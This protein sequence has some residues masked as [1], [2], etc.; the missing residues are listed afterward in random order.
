[1]E[2][3]DR[4]HQVVIIGGGFAGLFAARALRRAPVSV[5]LVD[6]AANHLFQPLLYQ[7]ATGILS[8]GKIAF[9]L[10]SLLSRH[11][12]VEAVLAEV[13]DFDA[14]ERK[15]LAV[16]P[17][18]EPVEFDYDELILAAGV[19]QSY[20]GHEEFAEFAPGMK[21]IDD[22]LAIRDRVFGAFEMAESAT[23]EQERRDWLTFALVGAGPTGVEL[24]GQ[25]RELATK[26]L[27]QEYRHIQPE[28]ARVLLLDAGDAPLASFG[29]K[30]SGKAA[31][32]LQDL[33]V[34]LHMKSMVTH[35]DNGWL[36]ARDHD[37]AERRY[38]AA[39]I[40]WTAGV[41]APPVAQALAQAAGA[42]RDKAGRIVVGPDLT[43]PDHPEISVIGDVMSL[44]D[45]PGVAEVAMQSGLYA[46]RRIRQRLAGEQAAVKPFRYYD[47]GSAAYIARGNAVVS[48]GPVQLSGVAGWISWL[49]IHLAFLT[50]VRNRLGAII[51]WWPAF[52]RD[53]RRERAYTTQQIE[54]LRRVY[55]SGR[56]AGAAEPSR[57]HEAAHPARER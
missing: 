34:E 29:A 48:A 57:P 47:L 39:T 2:S 20:F 19:E 26:T 21:T 41:A 38:D 50:G 10:R 23:D 36:R 31:E 4:Q 6:R 12:N 25:I 5:T 33:G 16:R 32:A 13:V 42:E 45:L 54:K 49:F 43:I 18:G 1:M 3:R 56:R 9:P 17:N 28:E 53:M 46:G 22:A 44:R 30:L 55:E 52:F 11:K 8:E 27:S 7:C 14:A 40:L 35:V 37:G 51:N 24:A 15:V